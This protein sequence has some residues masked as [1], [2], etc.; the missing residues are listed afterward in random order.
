DAK[1]DLVVH[2]G[3]IHS[4]KQFC[5]DAYDVAVFDLWQ[6][7]KDPL[8]YT[9][10]DNEWADCHKTAEG[11]GKYNSS[12]HAID[13]VLDGSGNLADY[14]GGDPVANLDLVRDIF[15]ANPGYSLGGRPK[16]VLSQ[17]QNFD[18]ANPT[19]ANYVENVIWE[20]S[21]VLFVTINLPG[22]SNN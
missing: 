6:D 7:F 8:I 1:V 2:V 4:G 9:P 12:T 18:P 3:D 15:F 14:A 5:T 19:D 21:K 17:A 20:Q 11:G 13:Y 16:Q 10:G 22:G